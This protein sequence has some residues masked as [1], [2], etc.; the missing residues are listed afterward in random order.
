MPLRTGLASSALALAAL[1]GNFAFAADAAEPPQSTPWLAPSITYDGTALAD[2]QGGG[3]R[4]STY[5]GNLHLKANVDGQAIGLAGTSAFI[6]VL[7]IHGGHPSRLVG[8]AQGTSNIEGPGGTQIEE[9]W[10]QHNTAGNRLSVLGGIYDLNSEFYRLQSA[11][12]F[13]NSAFGIG[14]EFAQSG[15]EGPSIFPRTAFGLRVD[16]KPDPDVVLRGALLN[17]VPVARP[18]GSHALFRRGDGALAVV[19]VGLLSRAS[20]ALNT[21]D[22]TRTRVGRFSTLSADERKIAFGAWKY[23]GRYADLSDVDAGGAPVM[24]RGSSGGYL[25]VERQLL[26]GDAADG[27]PRATAFVQAG[28]AD[29]RTNRF[30][31]HVGAG[32]VASGWRAVNAADQFGLSVTRAREGS[33]DLRSRTLA[34]SAPA[35]AETTLEANYLTQV[36]KGITVQPDLQYVVH[37]NAERSR[38]N[39]WVAQLRFEVAY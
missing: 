39:A 5:V 17:G 13:L 21:A 27:K 24:R 3:R 29:P 36:R 18:N 20:E 10:I 6:D 28:I 33:H 7:N 15:V 22:T 9:L 19:E 34:G 26:D 11:G 37:P 38:S 25:V 12:L 2:L 31:A 23:T 16:A 8:D 32:V 14:P 35:R 1:A 4:G 30:N